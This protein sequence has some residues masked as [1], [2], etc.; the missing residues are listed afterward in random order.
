[1]KFLSL[2]RDSKKWYR[3]GES[4]RCWHAK[5]STNVELVQLLCG[6]TTNCFRYAKTGAVSQDASLPVP[7]ADTISLS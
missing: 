4:F 7:V 2:I 1:M 3:K 5:R 6:R